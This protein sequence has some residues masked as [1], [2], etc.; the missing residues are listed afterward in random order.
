MKWRFGESVNYDVL[1][2]IA[3]RAADIIDDA[4][5]DHLTVRT[6]TAKCDGEYA[7]VPGDDDPLRGDGDCEINVKL[8]AWVRHPAGSMKNFSAG[9][10]Y[11]TGNTPVEPGDGIVQHS[12]SVGEAAREIIDKIDESEKFEF[13]DYKMQKSDKS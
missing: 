7:A 12:P 1:R 5:D 8:Q 9:R 2:E 13:L 6:V 3:E 11:A 4:I 10:V